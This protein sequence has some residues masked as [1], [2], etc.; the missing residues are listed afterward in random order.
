MGSNLRRRGGAYWFRRRVPDDLRARIGLVEINRSLRTST[1][2]EAQTRARHAWLATEELFA[3]MSKNL[4]MT[5]KQA[6]LIID[7][8][9]SEPVMNSPTAD[10]MVDAM[11]RGDSVT[12]KILFN[13][14]AMD[15]VMELPEEQRSHIAQHIAL[16]SERMESGIA[17]QQQE[18]E[19]LRNLLLRVRGEK[20]QARAKE[21][22]AALLQMQAS[23][24]VSADV[25][26]KLAEIG[27]D[28]RRAQIPALPAAASQPETGTVSVPAKQVD[29]KARQAVP[30]FSSLEPGFLKEKSREAD[31]HRPWAPETIKNFSLVS[32]LWRSIVGDLTVDKYTG[33]DAMRFRD[34]MLRMPS[35]HSKGGTKED[36]RAALSPFEQIRLADLK[37]AEI[38]RRNALLPPNAAREKKLD[39]MSMKTLKKHFSS[40]SQFWIHAE[41]QGLVGERNI[42]RGWEYQGVK[43]NGKKKR[44]PWSTAN[45]Q[46]LIDSPWF[47]EGDAGQRSDRS[48][49]TLIAMF[50]GLRVEEILRLRTVHDIRDFQPKEDGAAPIH[51]FVIQPHEAP[52]EWDPKSEAGSRTVPVHSFLLSLGF[53]DFVAARR[54]SGAYRLFT[55]GNNRASST[56]LSA[57]FVSDFSRMKIGLGVGPENT[58]HS[59][60][61]N[62][63]TMLRNTKNSD[64]REHWIDAILGHAGGDDDVGNQSG[65]HPVSE[66]LTTY[67]HGVDVENLKLTV[68]A[69]RYPAIDFSRVLAGVRVDRT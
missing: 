25:M 61:H 42:F 7:Q 53:M 58:F 32:H 64:F 21:A 56:K 15:Q 24:E 9:G 19:K 23:V 3:A 30:L 46:K 8:L 50:G 62:I 31:G 47:A 48:W 37:Q 45:L 14:E 54:A 11:L 41:R 38:D 27:A 34:T 1:R 44:L 66:G 35:S 55:P 6:K 20:A 12:T 18:A 57:K 68:E 22:E 5:A 65:R 4:S 29:A 63:S 43:R 59:A 36:V 16:I 10:E 60:R 49:V 39:R 28:V 52:H 26:A 67:Y 33:Q 17:R 2:Y 51:C 69:I 13:L 40:L